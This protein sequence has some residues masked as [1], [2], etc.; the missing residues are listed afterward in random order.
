MR[1]GV[2]VKICSNFTS[3]GELTIYPIDTSDLPQTD[4]RDKY[5]IFVNFLGIGKNVI[6]K[7]NSKL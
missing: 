4:F 1:N 5:T 6:F 7:T 3:Y 2:V